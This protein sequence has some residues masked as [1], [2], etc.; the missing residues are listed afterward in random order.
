MAVLGILLTPAL[1]PNIEAEEP[2]SYTVTSGVLVDQPQPLPEPEEVKDPEITFPGEACN[3]WQYVKNRLSA[4][5]RM[6]DT[7]PNAEAAVGAVAV[8]W[9]GKIKHVSI[10]TKVE[11]SGV[12]VEEANYIHC[13]TGERFIP[14]DKYSLV[15][16]WSPYGTI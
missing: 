12:W 7:N 5:G 4:L 1:P 15:G 16:F 6:A 3:C 11:V 8:E 9:F 14:F 13:E 10:V 2:P